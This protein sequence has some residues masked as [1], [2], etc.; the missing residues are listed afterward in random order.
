MTEQLSIGAAIPS[1]ARRTADDTLRDH[2]P[3]GPPA[4][5]PPWDPA[6]LAHLPRDQGWLLHQFGQGP[7][8]APS[9]PCIHHPV[10]E[11]AAA[12]PDATAAEH[13]GRSLTYGELDAQACRLAALLTEQGVRP[14]DRVGLFLRRSLP[15]LVGILAVLKTGAAYVPQDAEQAPAAQVE[16]VVRTAGITVVLTTSAY[17]E[18]LAVPAGTRLVAVDKVCEEPLTRC[19][20]GFRPLRPVQP[21]DVC[22]VLFTSGTTGRPNGVA[23]THRNVC[24]LLLTSPGDLGIRPGWRVGQILNIAFD[25]AAWEILGALVHG[26]TL[27]VRGTDTAAAVR[28]ADVIIATPSVLATLDPGDCARVRVVAVA[29]EPCPRTLADTWARRCTFYNGCGPTETTIVNTLQRHCPTAPSLTIGRPTPNNTVYIL[30]PRGRLC[31]PG[32]VGEMWAGGDGVSDG[33]LSAPDLTTQRYAP[34]PFLGGSRLMFRTRDLGRWTTEGELEHLG[35]TDD[36]VKVR[37]FRVE[38]DAV[39]TVLESVPGCER[40]VT[41]KTDDRT[42]MSFV[43]PAAVDAEAAR[44]AV[45]DALPYYC[46]PAVVHRLSH[47][48]QTDRGKVDKAALRRLAGLGGAA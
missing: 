12:L 4:R 6:F 30:D 41:L 9:H 29:G 35:R 13:E 47:L 33:Y 11:F 1:Q 7:V 44:A 34:D 25:M 36:Q 48:P 27:V 42:L 21:D 45:A 19:A 17:T 32:E 31:A 43:T 14:G 10:E 2:R 46:V 26:A 22:Y 18:R 5:R 40:A 15:M 16:H 37:G 39:S 23:V 3:S 38:L 24:N 28:D 8:A 20:P